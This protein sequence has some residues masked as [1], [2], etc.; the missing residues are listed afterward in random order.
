MSS[1]AVVQFTLLKLKPDAHLDEVGSPAGDALL[2][3]ISVVKK[4]DS[5]N[6]AFF[7]HQ[8]ENPDIGVLVFVYPSEEASQVF[9]TSS[10]P[11][12]SAFSLSASTRTFKFSPA[13]GLSAVLTCPTTEVATAYGVEEGY[14]KNM[15]TFS[16]VIPAE[17]KGKDVGFHGS[18][19]GTTVS[20]ISKEEGGEKAPAVTLLV[21]W[22]SREAHMAGREIA[23]PEKISLIRTLRKDMD[24]WHVNFK[25]Y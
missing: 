9:S 16:A 18:I 6:R 5:N 20:D 3:V 24:M 13:D 7:G 1:T 22:D 12:L 23:I 25:E 11:K 2:D 15:R 21:G 17:L 8:L 10:A 4:A 14:E 19:V